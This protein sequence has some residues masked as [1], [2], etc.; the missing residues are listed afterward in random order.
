[1]QL[2][3]GSGSADASDLGANRPALKHQLHNNL[4]RA[5]AMCYN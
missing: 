1:M 2:W 5:V 4:D 3:L